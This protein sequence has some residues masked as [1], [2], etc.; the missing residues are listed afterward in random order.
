MSQYYCACTRFYKSHVH[1]S[2]P[3]PLPPIYFLAGTQ[4]SEFAGYTHWVGI[5]M[6]AGM[7]EQTTLAAVSP[8]CSDQLPVKKLK[9]NWSGKVAQ[10][11]EYCS[12][13]WPLYLVNILFRIYLNSWVYVFF[14]P[15]KDVKEQL[16]LIFY[17]PQCLCSSQIEWVISVMRPKV[18]HYKGFYFKLHR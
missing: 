11:E 15:P 17:L 4:I 13:S 5:R 16:D 14:F 9:D 2:L 8:T 12:F 6:C 1:F 18:P 7:H 3:Q 10:L